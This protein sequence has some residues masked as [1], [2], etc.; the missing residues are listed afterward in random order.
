MRDDVIIY[1]AII[2]A[3][4]NC[5]KKEEAM[6]WIDRV[7]KRHHPLPYSVY[8][9]ILDCLKKLEEIEAMDILYQEAVTNVPL[10][11][12]LLFSLN[13]NNPPS[14]PTKGVLY[15]F[16][17]KARGIWGADGPVRASLWKF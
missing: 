1:G 3:L 6:Q 12:F 14:P 16:P 7:R 17:S 8:L 11:F 5:G 9:N 15:F 4:A 2:R 13:V 10:F